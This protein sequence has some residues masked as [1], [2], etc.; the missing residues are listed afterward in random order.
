MNNE[1]IMLDINVPA[2]AFDLKDIFD[3]NINLKDYLEKKILIAFFR[4]AGCPFCNTRVHSLQKK[5]E[6]LKAKGLEMIFF[7]ESKKELMLSSQFHKSISP[8]PLIS[9]PEKTWYSS[10]GVEKSGAKSTKSH[11]FSLLPKV[12]EAKL[13]GLPVHLIKGDESIKTIPAEFLVNER[14]LVK[15]MHY[16]NGLRE[17]MSLDIITE[18]AETGNVR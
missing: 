8:I 15:K 2:P 5:H 16:A 6:E 12:V 3:R 9:D 13:K 10:Y 18:F 14:G 4:H 17:R 7:F 11:I 1:R